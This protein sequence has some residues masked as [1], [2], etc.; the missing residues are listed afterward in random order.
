MLSLNPLFPSYRKKARQCVQLNMSTQC[1]ATAKSFVGFR[2]SCVG[3]CVR[4]LERWRKPICTFFRVK[5]KKL[6]LS[7][8]KPKRRI[9]KCMYSPIHSHLR[10][11]IEVVVCL[12]PRHFRGV[13]N[14]RY[15]SNRKENG[16]QNLSGGFG[17][18]INLL[19]L[20]EFK[21]RTVH[22]VSV[23]TVSIEQSRFIFFGLILRKLKCYLNLSLYPCVNN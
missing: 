7:L 22:P 15:P 9:G 11:L 12:K 19:L 18:R 4:N 6:R 13:K 2:Y 20:T 3:V 8:Y 10:H 21:P 23:I 17:E 5:S 14:S 16:T 1:G